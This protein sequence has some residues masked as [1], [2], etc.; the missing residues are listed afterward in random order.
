MNTL[1]TNVEHSEPSQVQREDTEE[2]HIAPFSTVSPSILDSLRHLDLTGRV[3]TQNTIVV[4]LGAYGDIS[5][6]TLQTEERGKVNVA[7]K[8]LRIHLPADLKLVSLYLV[9]IC[10]YSRYL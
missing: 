9:L 10:S 7:V 6:G 1:D 8:R 4:S 2:A 3:D 5:R